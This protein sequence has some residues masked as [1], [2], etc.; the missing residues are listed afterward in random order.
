ML[1]SEVVPGVRD[2][3]DADMGEKLDLERLSPRKLLDLVDEP[4]YRER[5]RERESERERETGNTVDKAHE[6]LQ[7]AGDV[8]RRAPGDEALKR[9]KRKTRDYRENKKKKPTPSGSF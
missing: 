8:P 5:E 2:G 6:V 3:I 4:T 9:E 1:V 7:I